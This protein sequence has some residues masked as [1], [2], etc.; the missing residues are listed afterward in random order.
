[1]T[2]R[3]RPRV[4]GHS[5]RTRRVRRVSA[6]LS[7]LRAGAGLAML[8]SA[9]G[10]YGVSASSAFGFDPARLRVDGLHYTDQAELTA[11]LAIPAGTNLFSLSTEPL[12][13]RVM[14]LTTVA[15]V[16]LA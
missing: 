8:L 10:I 14:Q 15:G 3:F 12:A 6:V 7:P 1:M 2:A 11:S 13:T 16:E 9:A 5:R 4:G